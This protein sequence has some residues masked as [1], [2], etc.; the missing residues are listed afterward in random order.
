M[1]E[2]PFE[3]HHVPTIGYVIWKDSTFMH[4]VALAY[5]IRV[6]MAKSGWTHAIALIS[7]LGTRRKYYHPERQEIVYDLQV[8]F[9]Y[10]EHLNYAVEI[11][12]DRILN[13]PRSR[14]LYKLRRCAIRSS[15]GGHLIGMLFLPD[16]ENNEVID[17]VKDSLRY[18]AFGGGIL[19]I[20]AL[21]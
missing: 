17:S 8:V 12:L 18:K 21:H 7:W 9:A 4:G 6:M 5:A 2:M 15:R 1:S 3:K 14:Y 13:D 11:C 10:S 19:E 20:P 16:G